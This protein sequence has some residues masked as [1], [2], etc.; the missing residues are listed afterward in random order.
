[1]LQAGQARQPASARTF[2]DDDLLRGYAF[3]A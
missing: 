3:G 1:M 2:G